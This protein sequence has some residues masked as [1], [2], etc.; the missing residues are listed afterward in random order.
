MFELRDWR[1]LG[2]YFR[3]LLQKLINLRVALGEILIQIIREPWVETL[4]NVEEREK[5]LNELVG[6]HVSFKDF[7]FIEYSQKFMEESI[8]QLRMND[9]VQVQV[10]VTWTLS[11]W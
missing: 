3:V 5:G 11:R 1:L 9:I 7:I 4:F 8:N 10:L 6:L 2:Q